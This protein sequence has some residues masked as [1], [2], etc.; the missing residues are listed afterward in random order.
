MIPCVPVQR[1]LVIDARWIGEREIELHEL[2]NADPDEV[3]E[4]V[5]ARIK[6]SRV[7][8][9]NGNVA[10]GGDEALCRCCWCHI[11][12]TRSVTEISH[13]RGLERITGDRSEYFAGCVQRVNRVIER[14]NLIDGEEV[15]TYVCATCENEGS[16]RLLGADGC[17][18]GRAGLNQ[19]R[20]AN[21][22][23]LQKLRAPSKLSGILKRAFL[24]NVDEQDKEKVDYSLL[25]CLANSRLVLEFMN[26]SA[27]LL[28]PALVSAVGRVCSKSENFK[29]LNMKRYEPRKDKDDTGS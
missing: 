20:V 13:V 22:H 28:A 7:V 10:P 21:D 15:R 29:Q 3:G 25:G 24:D 14:V 5:L 11:C 19:S 18:D 2:A 12:D 4:E 23:A 9:S 16:L 1:P 26:R 8:D 6:A 27:E 17:G